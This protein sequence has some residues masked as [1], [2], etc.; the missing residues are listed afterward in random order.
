MLVLTRRLGESIM[1]D[2]NIEVQVLEVKGEQVRIGITAPIDVKVYRKEIYT[3]ILQE[4]KEA[5]KAPQ[6]DQLQN[7]LNKIKL[8]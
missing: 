3:A 6:M 5:S 1:L 4:N 7:I 2:G 8:S